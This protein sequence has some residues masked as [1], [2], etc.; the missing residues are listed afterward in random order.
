MGGGA[1]LHAGR[2][3]VGTA[4]RLAAP[5][6]RDWAGRVADAARTAARASR[7]TLVT[8]RFT[9]RCARRAIGHRETGYAGAGKPPVQRER[10]DHTLTPTG[11]R[12]A[13]AHTAR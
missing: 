4:D 1:A 13:P 6:A 3:R 11:G 12:D 2:E 5:Y 8:R 9:R 7:R 10:S